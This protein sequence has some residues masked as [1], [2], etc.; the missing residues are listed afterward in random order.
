[1]AKAERGK[2]L[3]P[4]FERNGLQPLS[5]R[6]KRIL[7]LTL[8]SQG[9]SQPDIAK[10]SGIAQQTVSRLVK[11]LLDIGALQESERQSHGRR[12]QPSMSVKTSPDF[13]YTFGISMMLDA[14]SVILVDF[15]GN[16]LAEENED[17]PSMSR[18]MVLST[19][20]H[21]L[22]SII[23]KCHI[24]KNRIFGAGV[25]ISGYHLGGANLLN[26]PRALDDWAL[27]NIEDMLSE[28]L[29]MP[30]WVENDG[31]VAAIGESLVGV[32]RQ[33]DNFAYIFIDAL[34]GGGVIMNH[35]LLRGEHG[36]AGEVG[37][38][39][40]S[41]IYPHPNLELLR[42]ILARRGMNFTSLPE[43]LRQ[44]DPEWPGVEEWVTK[45]RDSLSVITS[46]LTAI[47]DP[48]AIVL[49][50]R[51]PRS[52]GEKIIPH[53]E[54]YDHHR[55]AQPRPLPQI[56]LAETPGDACAIGAATLPFKK[57]FFPGI[58]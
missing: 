13:A 44:F 41:R 2:S 49:G 25:G 15:S 50:G 17:M 43:L 52:L 51:L 19:L 9:V 8:R 40:P 18:R 54:V 20:D 37:L 46:A 47:L 31:N 6:E 27:I 14:L 28:R 10:K 12:G 48:E 56:L 5:E 36:N 4:F 53:I 39:L 38:I 30:V 29:N 55:R 35:E 57:F 42:Q 23:E 22:A 16:V 45:S 1:M 26:T 33:F 3:P 32:G 24:D 21:M 58:A 34:V 7:S 11:G